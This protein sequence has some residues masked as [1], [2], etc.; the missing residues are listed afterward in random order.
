MYIQRYLKFQSV[1][2]KARQF[3]QVI[4]SGLNGCT[5]MGQ[6]VHTLT[7]GLGTNTLSR[8]YQSARISGHQGNFHRLLNCAPLKQ[9]NLC[10]LLRLTFLL[11]YQQHLRKPVLQCAYDTPPIYFFCIVMFVG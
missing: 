5:L 4:S 10:C 6:M 8:K 11:K 9:L 3:F 7:Q 1:L 2:C